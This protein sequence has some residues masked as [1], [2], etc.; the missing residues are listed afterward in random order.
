VILAGEITSRAEV[1]HDGVVR[2]AV[3]EV[4][5]SDPDEPFSSKKLK[6]E[7]RL[8]AQSE[9][10]D[11]GIGDGPEQG[12]GDQGVMTG[13]ATAETPERLHMPHVLAH[14]ITAG[15]ARDRRKGVAQWLRPD[16]KAQVSVAYRDDEPD[17]VRSVVVSTQHARGVEHGEI[18]GYVRDELLPRALGEWFHP[19]IEL[20]VN[21]TGRFV[22]GG[23]AVDCGLTGRKIVVD[24]YGPSVPVGGGAFSGKDPSKVDRSAAYFC[25]LAA[26]WVVQAKL[27][28]QVLI[29]VSYAIGVE[30]PLSLHVE[31]VGGAPRAEVAG[32]VRERFDFRPAAMIERLDLRRPIY[33]ST[34]NYGHFGRAGLPWEE[35]SRVE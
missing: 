9:D 2:R 26:R 12:A 28:K 35:D 7:Q 18:D 3:E 14:R 6:V 33:R 22:R 34:T 13:F 31:P 19:A 24:A 5:Y 10:I 32:R 4:G 29:Q 17:E 16:G 23:P 21:P 20:R 15:L 30:E 25:R 1:D 11:R 8:T 27:A